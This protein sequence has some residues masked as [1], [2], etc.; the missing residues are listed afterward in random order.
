MFDKWIGKIL[1]IWWEAQFGCQINEVLR[2]CCPDW[3]ALKYG[4]A[5]SV[6]KTLGM[7]QVLKRE[8]LI[9]DAPE[10]HILWALSQ[11]NNPLGHFQLYVFA[12]Y[13]WFWSCINLHECVCLH[14]HQHLS[15]KLS[16]RLYIPCIQGQA[17]ELDHLNMQLICEGGTC[18]HMGHLRKYLFKV[19]GELTN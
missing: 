9:K 6:K 13:L 17:F 10:R 8:V 18:S 5:S 1:T 11:H 2:A 12:S 14:S 15:K 7:I 16:L 19:L 3:F 4:I